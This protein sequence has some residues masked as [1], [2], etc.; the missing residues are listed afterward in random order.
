MAESSWNHAESLSRDWVAM[1]PD[2]L[3]RIRWARKFPSLLEDENYRNVSQRTPAS[4]WCLARQIRL[5][6]T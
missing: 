3:M 4:E 1:K 6:T 2:S 5:F